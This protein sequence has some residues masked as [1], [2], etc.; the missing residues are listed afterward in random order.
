MAGGS[1][2]RFWPL[3]TPAR[4]KQL[5]NLTGDGSLL[6]LT[7]QRIKDL[8]PSENIYVFTG[9]GIQSAVGR[10]IPELSENQIVAEPA[11]RNTAPCIAAA[12]LWLRRKHPD[13]TM[14]VLPADHLITDI[15]KFH[16]CLK[17]ADALARVSK[18]L[19]TLGIKP[20][21]AETGFGY[22][23]ADPERT[24]GRGFAVKGF[25]EKPDSATAKRYLAR[26]HFFW[27]SG[28]FVWKVSSILESLYMHLPEL[29]KILKPLESAD[30][31]EIWWKTFKELFPKTP[32]VSVDYGVLE[33]AANVYVV[34]ATFDWNDIGSWPALESIR[35]RD[36]HGNIVQGS[37]RQI[38]TKDCMII[39]ESSVPL[40]TI[41]VKD[42]I[43]V[44]TKDGVLVC[45]KDK[46][47]E[48]RQIKF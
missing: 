2:T 17:E 37:V 27:N 30:K 26:K 12:A 4:P 7:Y 46:A 13:E 39:N 9:E 19:V 5:L 35:S 16:R 29:M 33:K 25:H 15:A 21:R 48:I 20:T 38:E 11:A 40:A 18:G 23:E 24:A 28:I 10:E 14:V 3:S 22:I 8:V 32:S 31:P 44:S 47:Q 45:H 41:G 36:A 34:P 1:G 6:Q 42:L 43:I